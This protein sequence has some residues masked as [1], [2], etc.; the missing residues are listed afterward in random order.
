MFNNYPVL[1]KVGILLLDA[2]ITVSSYILAIYARNLLGFSDKVSWHLYINMLLLILVVWSA[3]SE[4]QEAYAGKA[5]SHSRYVGSFRS[6]KDDLLIIVRT[7]IFGCPLV[8]VLSLTLVAFTQ[9]YI[10]WGGVPKSL[11]FFFGLFNLILLSLEKTVIHFVASN[12]HNKDKHSKKVLILGSGD[13]AKHFINKALDSP[14]QVISILGIISLDKNDIGKEIKGF[15]ILETLDH[16][17]RVLHSIYIDELIVALP[18]KHMGN[19]EEVIGTCDKEGVPVRVVSP[20]FKDLISK[21]RAEVTY[22]LTNIMFLPV[23]R[24]DLEMLIKRLID[25]VISFAGLIVLAP[26]FAVT[27][28]LIKLNSPGPVFYKW[29]ILGLHKKPLTSYKFRTMIVNADSLKEDL[30]NSNEMS[31]AAFKMTRDPR[32]T[33]LGRWL[34]KYSLD[35]LPQ[36][37]SVLT[38]DL[39]LVGPRPPLQTEVEYYEGWHRRKLSVKPGITCLWQISGRNV[40]NDFDEWVIL[41]LKYIDNW[42]LWLDIKILFKTVFAVF[43][44][45]GK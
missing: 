7:V 43:K 27:A 11:I 39:S 5:Y 17:T 24:N 6:L 34:R 12:L 36:L 33:T 1:S 37:W 20:F 15:K 32:I 30:V 10:T 45:T 44:G 3:L 19:I 9:F 21:S 13:T 38:G 4:Y 8:Y 35:E 41:D 18:A 22:G 26:L 42:S 31:G 14:G 29:K 2:V 25:I 16:L 28:V 23:E 40:I